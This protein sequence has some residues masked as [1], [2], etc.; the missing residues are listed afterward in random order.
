MDFDAVSRDRLVT[1]GVVLDRVRQGADA[2]HGACPFPRF[3][4]MIGALISGDPL[5]CRRAFAGLAPEFK[6]VVVAALETPNGKEKA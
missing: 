4:L 6:D 5:A 2:A 3:M 1:A